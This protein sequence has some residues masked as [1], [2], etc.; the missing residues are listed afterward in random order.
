MDVVSGCFVAFVSHSTLL[1]ATTN[2]FTL[3][4]LTFLVHFNMA[5]LMQF[6]NK[7]RIN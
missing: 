7:G 6:L 2:F 5:K 1:K 4:L 3:Q